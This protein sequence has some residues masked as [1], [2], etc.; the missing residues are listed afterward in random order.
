MNN[1][2][3]FWASIFFIIYLYSSFKVVSIKKIKYSNSNNDFQIAKRTKERRKNDDK[4]L[5]NLFLSCISLS[6]VVVI[7]RVPIFDYLN[8]FDFFHNMDKIASIRGFSER[9]IV[10]APYLIYLMIPV[11]IRRAIPYLK[12]KIGN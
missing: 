2:I 8:G 7:L 5:L 12:N 3:I 4:I 9:I 10:T 1:Y 11:F 6:L